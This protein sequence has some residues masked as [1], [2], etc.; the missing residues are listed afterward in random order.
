[1]RLSQECRSNLSHCCLVI[2]KSRSDGRKNI[3]TDILVRVA[4]ASMP[5][6]AC[7]IAQTAIPGTGNFKQNAF[8]SSRRFFNA[9][10]SLRFSMAASMNPA[11]ISISFSFMPRVV[12]A[13]VPRRTPEGPSVFWCHWDRVLVERHSPL[14][15]APSPLRPRRCPSFWM[16]STSIRWL[17]VPFVMSLAPRSIRYAARC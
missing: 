14:H 12:M 13:G 17:S 16:Q 4:Q 8:T 11:R 5:A 10:A 2:A 9:A 7:L 3:E 6:P 15:R 1:M